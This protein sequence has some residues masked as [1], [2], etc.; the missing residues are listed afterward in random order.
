[1]SDVRNTSVSQQGS[2][3]IYYIIIFVFSSEAICY[4]HNSFS[5]TLRKMCKVRKNVGGA[6]GE[7]CNTWSFEGDIMIC[8]L[9][10]KRTYSKKSIN[11]FEQKSHADHERFVVKL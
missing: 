1:M 6:Q 4:A 2:K 7:Q 10:A 9:L 11:M 3:I 5:Y 8:N